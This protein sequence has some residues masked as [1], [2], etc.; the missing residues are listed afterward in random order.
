MAQTLDPALREWQRLDPTKPEQVAIVTSHRG[1]TL[2]AN[3]ETGDVSQWPNE[4][5]FIPNSV[6][7]VPAQVGKVDLCKNLHDMLDMA[8]ERAEVGDESEALNLIDGIAQRVM[9]VGP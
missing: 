3:T 2:L 5:G 6:Y 7:F 4:V 9:E 1:V 8:L